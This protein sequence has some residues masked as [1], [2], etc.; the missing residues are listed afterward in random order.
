VGVFNIS[1]AH[2]GVRK[3]YF[4]GVGASF[5]QIK[6]GEYLTGNNILAQV[7]AG[8][9]KRHFLIIMDLPLTKIINMSSFMRMRKTA[10][11]L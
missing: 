2:I 3:D 5:N 7:N 9:Q 8:Q 1:L 6:I 4:V 11:A 10:M